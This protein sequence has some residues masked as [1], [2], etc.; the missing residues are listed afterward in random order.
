MFNNYLY[1]NWTKVSEVNGQYLNSLDDLSISELKFQ[2]LLSTKT[3][4]LPIPG[5]IQIYEIA[6]SNNNSAQG[7]IMVS[8]Y[9]ANYKL[10]RM[11]EAIA[12]SQYF[13]EVTAGFFSQDINPN[14]GLYGWQVTVGIPLWITSQQAEIKQYK[15]KSEIALNELKYNKSLITYEIENLKYTLN[16]YF[17]QILHYEQE[18]LP[19]A[20]ILIQTAEYQLQAEEIDFTEFLQSV[21]LAMQI[22]SDYLSV[23]NLYNQTS[24]Q[25]EIYEK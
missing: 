22:R 5:E 15:I 7:D 25:L 14:N 21:S 24:I 12:K 23:I 9:N 3:Q 20:E 8:Y 4:L 1:S 10:A 11:N 6:R 2:Q 16:K 18:A 19:Q 17:R 13:P